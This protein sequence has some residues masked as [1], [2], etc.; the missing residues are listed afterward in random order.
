MAAKK[1]GFKFVHNGRSYEIPDMAS[2][3]TGVVRK[4]RRLENDSDKAFT[5]LELLLGEDSPELAAV[6]SMNGAEFADWLTAWTGGAPL[7]ES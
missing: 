3:P 4:T 1:Q 2:I 7:G 5:I 6:D